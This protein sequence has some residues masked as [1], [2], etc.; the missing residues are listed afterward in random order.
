MTD[1]TDADPIRLAFVCVQNWAGLSAPLA[2]HAGSEVT[3]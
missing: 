1:F 3:S 2:L